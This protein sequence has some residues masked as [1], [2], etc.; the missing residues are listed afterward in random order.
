LLTQNTGVIVGASDDKTGNIKYGGDLIME[1]TSQIS[2][3]ISQ[4]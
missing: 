2:V 4:E 1:S 3:V